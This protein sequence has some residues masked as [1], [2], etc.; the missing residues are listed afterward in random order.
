MPSDAYS[1]VVRGGLKLKGSAG[2]TKK[3]KKK[4][5]EKEGEVGEGK[6][7]ALQKALEDEDSALSKVQGKGKDMEDGDADGKLAEEGDRELE[8]RGNDG[9]T[10]SERAYE[11]M[12]RKRVCISISVLKYGSE[13]GTDIG[14]SY[15]RDCRKK[16]L[17]RIKKRWRS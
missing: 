15:M 13:A 10:A 7:E 8:E 3:K 16:G 5:K 14:V 2:I 9:K 6:K 4:S 12:R 11:E 1:S 17:R